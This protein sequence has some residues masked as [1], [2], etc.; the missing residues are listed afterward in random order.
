VPNGAFHARATRWLSRLGALGGR[1]AAYP[2]LHAVALTP[3]G[4]RALAERAG[5]EEVEV[6]NSVPAARG[7][8]LSRL[9]PGVAAGAGAAAV[10]SRHRW[11]LGPSL[12]LYG[13][14]R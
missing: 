14:R 8:I 3:G 4:L 11:L 10:V 13:V 1:L 12:E 6:R 7:G 2:V 5:F 9:R